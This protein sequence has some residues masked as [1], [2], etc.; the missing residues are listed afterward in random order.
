MPEL[1]VG[2]TTSAKVT[3]ARTP[4]NPKDKTAAI[5]TMARFTRRA[6]SAAP[7]VSA[8]S[9]TLTPT[10]GLTVTLLFGRYNTE[11]EWGN[12]SRHCTS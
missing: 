6:S 11:K 12:L 4:K 7:E 9:R 1:N 10:R 8:I 3:H 5:S 2:G